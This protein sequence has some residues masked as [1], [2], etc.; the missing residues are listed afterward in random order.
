[1][2]DRSLY[3]LDR[4]LSEGENIFSILVMISRH[5]RMIFQCKSLNEKGLKE[6]AI[7]AKSMLIRIQ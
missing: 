3:F 2:P 5:I 4:L 7:S 1:M 6:D